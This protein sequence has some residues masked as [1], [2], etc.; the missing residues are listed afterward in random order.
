MPLTPLSPRDSELDHAVAALAGRG[1]NPGVIRLVEAWAAQGT[2]TPRARLAAARAFFHL[3]LMDRALSRVREALDAA[4]EDAEALLLLARVYVERGWP[5]KA[6]RPLQQLRDA[7]QEDTELW[8]RANADPVRPEANAREIEREGNPA[9]L[10]ALAEAF[11]ATGSFLRATGI[12]ER[13]RRSDPENPRLAE[14]LWGLAGDFRPA[15]PMDVLLARATPALPREH[16][17][18]EPEHTESLDLRAADLDPEHGAGATFPALFK[19]APSTT[20]F[21]EDDPQEATQASAL[22]SPDAGAAGGTEG[23]DPGRARLVE[24]TKADEG[25]TQI[26]LV[27][28]PGDERPPATHRRRDEEDPLRETLNLRAWQASMGVASTSDL[29]DTADDLLE[30]E[31]DDR[32]V[33]TQREAAPVAAPAERF[34][35]PIEVVEKHAAPVPAPPAPAPAPEPEPT[36]P[37]NRPIAPVLLLAGV[38]A[39]LLM[40]FIAALALGGLATRAAGNEVREDVVRALAAADYAAL[41]ATEGRLEQQLASGA[42]ASDLADLQAAL[43]E[44]RVAIWSEYNGD[45]ARLA[46]VREALEAPGSL[47]VHRLAL[48]RA[49]EALAREDIAGA[50]A[51]LGRERPEDDEERLLFARIAARGGDL[52]RALSHL[53]ALD[54][55][56]D[57][58]YRLARARL[59]VD[60]GRGD[61]ATLLV[62]A[63]LEADPTHAAANVQRIERLS[64]SPEVLVAEVE[65]F[66]NSVA[67]A[68]LAPRLDGRLEVVRARAFLAMGL[69]GQAAEAVE[70]GLSRDGANPDLLFLRAAEYAETQRLVPALQTLQP[71]VDA[72]PGRGDLRAAHTLLLLDLERAEEARVAVAELVRSGVLPEL[73]PVL[74]TLVSVWGLQAAPGVE[75]LPTQRETALGSVAAAALAFFNLEVGAA[76]ALDVAIAAARASDDPFVR[77]LAPRLQAMKALAGGEVNGE[78]AITNA[79]AA[80]PKDPAVHVH[81]ARYYERD[82]QRVRASHHFERAVQVGVEF[83]FGWYELGRFYEDAGD[84]QELTS[85][86]WRTFLALGPS[87]PRAE[88]AKGAL[89]LLQRP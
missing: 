2:P 40:I 25:D 71:V 84:G 80:A 75:L 73:T 37:P 1:D 70:R 51:A 13:L 52:E 57:P 53:D 65:R 35:R 67:G 22:A 3:R 42:R 15:E 85:D 87:G 59:L 77:R 66:R 21:S 76:D 56:E 12:L 55:P 61:E 28:R 62:A 60:A 34:D 46:A 9:R 38:G 58:R 72:H 6:R 23:T 32:V 29:A 18:E 68:D 49:A 8:A 19:Y 5:H 31:D 41:I 89:A 88:R 86:A 44:T 33:M 54:R 27:L 36:A 20:A 7:G 63:V 64:G 4:P 26:M 78:V 24:V 16:T 30:E 47:E 82:G 50:A 39:L 11:T 17:L 74:S 14:L 48:L 83:G 10:L 69:P 45:P 81:V 43:A 79:L